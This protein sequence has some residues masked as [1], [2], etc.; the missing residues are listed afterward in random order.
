MT[1]PL[2]SVEER[3]AHL[4]RMMDDMS[5]VIARQDG[6]ITRLRQQVDRLMHR[7][8]ER[9]SEQPGGVVIGDERPPH[10]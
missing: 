4:I 7:E 9:Q 10:Y 5:D 3:L 6:E 2:L 8:A 1:D